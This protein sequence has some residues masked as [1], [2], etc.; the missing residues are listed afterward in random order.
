MRRQELYCGDCGQVWSPP[1]L[2]K[3]EH[4]ISRYKLRFSIKYD[5]YPIEQLE[6][7]D[8]TYT[9]RNGKRIVMFRLVSE[10]DAVQ[11]YECGVCHQRFTHVVGEF[12]G[13]NDLP[14]TFIIDQSS[15]Q[16]E[17]GLDEA[18]SHYVNVHGTAQIESDG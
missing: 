8:R 1:F 16:D 4:L 15:N 3:R 18:Q 9:D 17:P 12:L 6:N 13:P 2:L 7:G 5:G 10:I 11:I 14:Y